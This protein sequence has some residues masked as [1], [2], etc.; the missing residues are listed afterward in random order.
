MKAFSSFLLILLLFNS[1]KKTTAPATV[2]P[3]TPVAPVTPVQPTVK[4][5]LKTADSTVEINETVSGTKEAERLAQNFRASDFS[6]TGFYLPAFTPMEIEVTQINGNRLPTLLVGT[7]SRYQS[8]WDPTS[9]TLNNGINTIT[10]ASG[11]IIYLRF[12]NDNPSS[13]VKVKFI[14][15]MKPIPYFQLGKTLQADWVKMIDNITDVPDVQLVGK[16]TI[17]TFSL[18]NAKVYK[19]DDQEAL[20]RK[21][22]RVIAIEDSISGLIGTDPIDQPNVH[23]Y[24][25]TES[26]HPGYFMAATFYRTWYG[27]TTGGVPSIL[28]ADNLTWGPWHELGHMHQQGAW[29]WSEL[30][31]VTVNIYSIAVEKAFGITPT[32]LTSQNEWNN[33]ATY[34]ASAEGVRNYNA[35]S[36]SVW[37]RLC[38]FQQLKLAFGEN[39]YQELH[40]QARR[41]TIKPT[42]TDAKMRWFMLKACSISGKNLSI[43]F[44]KWGMNLSS[45]SATDGV[46]TDIASLGL[47]APTQDLTLLKD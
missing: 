13:K 9:H 4:P 22:D 24:L 2:T 30:T 37:V 36:T 27:S 10:D 18:A 8:K 6:T 29:T 35:S 47:P 40:R 17:I 23:K 26:D 3:V 31:E 46:H 28:K 7:Y 15:G 14:R 38:M 16:K 19:N 5:E 21:A 32:R 33:T 43:F 12:N 39:F 11:G 34:L 1:C 45:Q 42:T 25:M 41:E 44:K 20:I